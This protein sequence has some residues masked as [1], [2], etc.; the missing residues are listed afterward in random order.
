MYFTSLYLDNCLNKFC[1]FL[2]GLIFNCL[3]TVFYGLRYLNKGESLA[4]LDFPNNLIEFQN[5]HFPRDT[6]TKCL[7]KYHKVFELR[8][9]NKTPFQ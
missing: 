5:L 1:N 8:G 7:K 6:T 3:S 2:L 9:G 4:S